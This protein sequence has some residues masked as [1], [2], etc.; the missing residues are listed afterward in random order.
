MGYSLTRENFNKLL[1]ELSTEHQIYAPVR[2]KDKGA[3]SDTDLITYGKVSSLDEI[4]FDQ[5][6]R[7]SPKEIILPITQTLFYFT[8]DEFS[9][10]SS[11][12][13]GI[14]VFLRPCD[15]NGI[16]RLDQIFLSNGPE[17]DVYYERIR[18]KVKFFVM[19]CVE[20][21]STCFCVSMQTNKTDDYSVFVRVEGDRVLCDVREDF[22]DAIAA[23]GQPVDFKP[24]FVKENQVAVQVPEEIDQSLY[25]H[26]MWQEYN[27]RCIACGRCNVSC[28]TCSCFSMQD[29]Y[30]EDNGNCGE[31]RR[32][33]AG[34]MVDGFTDMAGGHS[35]RKE[36]G[37]R[38]RFK[39]L[40]KIYDFRKR[41]GYNMCVGCGRCDDVCPE[42]ISFSNSINKLHALTR[43]VK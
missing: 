2:V 36:Y 3:F 33:W 39:V 16:K 23:K 15:V 24:A 20:S 27:S 42:Y 40:H 22:K 30:Y 11:S 9:E 13:S 25:G 41:F 32:V 8:E 1:A 4:V 12:D 31:R 34:C 5:K 38:M 29:I 26:E 17:A 21:F 7:F 10:P 14:I 28:P 35:F 19:E 18:N 43:E 37:D 6:S